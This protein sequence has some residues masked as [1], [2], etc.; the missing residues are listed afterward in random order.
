M[1][2]FTP[3]HYKRAPS[4][5]DQTHTSISQTILSEH[6]EIL[7]EMFL[8]YTY[9]YTMKPFFKVSLGPVDSSNKLRKNLN[10]GN[11]T[12]SFLTTLQLKNLNNGKL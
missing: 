8:G 7:M 11:L 10:E 4:G 1:D 12:M 6:S 2:F 3:L 9:I 5:Q